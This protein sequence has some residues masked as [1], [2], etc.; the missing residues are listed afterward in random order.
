MHG[1]SYLRLLYQYFIPMLLALPQNNN[2]Q[3]DG[4]AACYGSQVRHLLDTSSS[5]S[6]LRRGGLIASLPH[7][8]NLSLL[9]FL[10]WGFAKQNVYHTSCGNSTQLK[11]RITSAIHS[12]TTDALQNVGKNAQEHLNSVVRKNRGHIEQPKRYK[13]TFDSCLL[14]YKTF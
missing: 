6:C 2:L 4:A 5:G 3:R 13:K 9:D 8:R 11:G 7:L 10:N 1:E 12:I 14:H